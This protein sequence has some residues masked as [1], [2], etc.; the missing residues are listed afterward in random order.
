MA[1]HIVSMCICYTK[2]NIL[3]LHNLQVSYTADFMINAADK[4]SV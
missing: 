4:N 1:A 3:A 2:W